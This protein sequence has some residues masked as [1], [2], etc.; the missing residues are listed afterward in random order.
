MNVIPISLLLH[1]FK[2]LRLTRE[3]ITLSSR[4]NLPSWALGDIFMHEIYVENA[5]RGQEMLEQLRAENI[6]MMNRLRV[7]DIITSEINEQ[8]I[9][10]RSVVDEDDRVSN[11]LLDVLAGRLLDEVGEPIQEAIDA[12]REEL[13]QAARDNTSAIRGNNNN[14]EIGGVPDWVRLAFIYLPLGA[15][16]LARLLQD[17]F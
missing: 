14:S 15:I 4:A 2:N 9:P 13:V 7:V 5:Q 3:Q 16:V 12:W 17:R 6:L 10:P 8:R 1:D 11:E